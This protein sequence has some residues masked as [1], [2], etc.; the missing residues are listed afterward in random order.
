MWGSAIALFFCCLIALTKN[1]TVFIPS[2][3]YGRLDYKNFIT[4]YL[5]IPLMIAGWKLVKRTKGVTPLTA[6][7]YTGKDIIDADEQEW[8][9]REA[10]E[11]A[12]GRAPNVVYRHTLG[13]LF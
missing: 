2:A 7:L 13:Y 6:D 11:K 4:G 12:S 5:G 9:A 3:S 10:A 1:F 8:L